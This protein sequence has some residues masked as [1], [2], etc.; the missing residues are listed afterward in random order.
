MIFIRKHN[1]WTENDLLLDAKR[2]SV[3]VFLF[4][5]LDS[6]HKENV[7]HHSNIL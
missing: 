2:F 5:R 6:G 4:R 1:S 7:M 3:L